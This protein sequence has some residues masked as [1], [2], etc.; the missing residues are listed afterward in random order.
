MSKPASGLDKNV[1]EHFV[2]KGKCSIISTVIAQGFF[3]LLSLRDFIEDVLLCI[4][5]SNK[6]INISLKN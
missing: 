6:N 5:N 1:S 2:L 4:V 3:Y